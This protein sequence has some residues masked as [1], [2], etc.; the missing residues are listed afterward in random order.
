MPS[1]VCPEC[2]SPVAFG[3]SDN[4]GTEIF[5]DACGADLE[6]RSLHPVRLEMCEKWD[7]DDLADEEDGGTI[8]L[9][10]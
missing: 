6:I 7:E 2:D 4:P 8:H 1:G 5:C 3:S 10:N 9:I